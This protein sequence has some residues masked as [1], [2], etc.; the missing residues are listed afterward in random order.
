API[1]TNGA[2]LEIVDLLGRKVMGISLEPAS[3]LSV[4]PAET[5]PSGDYI[6][7]LRDGARTETVKFHWEK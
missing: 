6:A 3:A 4:L 2:A 5:V 1:V 7:R